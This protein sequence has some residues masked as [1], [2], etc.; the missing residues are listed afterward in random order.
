MIARDIL[1]Y[2]E[3]IQQSIVE[4]SEFT[5]DMT[6]KQFSQDKKTINAVIRSIEV[7]GEA[8]KKI[9]EQ[10]RIRYKEIPWKRM[11]GMRDKVIH[12]YFGIDLK[13]LWKTT[14]IDI[15]SIKPIIESAIENEKK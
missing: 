13:I 3:D 15:P 6:F 10:I 8:A 9:P 14:K 2:L 5:Q 7:M 1:D 11:T 12:E 4:V